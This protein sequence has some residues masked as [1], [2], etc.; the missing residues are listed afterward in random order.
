MVAHLLT[1]YSYTLD[2]AHAVCYA[3]SYRS[4]LAMQLPMLSETMLVS[5]LQLFICRRANSDALL[6][7]QTVIM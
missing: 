7:T 1:P 6:L 3:A 5:V 4:M 2:D